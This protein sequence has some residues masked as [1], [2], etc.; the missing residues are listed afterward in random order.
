MPDASV[1]SA[2]FSHCRSKFSNSD[3]T[4]ISFILDGGTLKFSPNDSENFS[5]GFRL[6]LDR[7]VIVKIS[8]GLRQ[9]FEIF[10]IF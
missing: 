5:S 8:F 2:K 6:Y 7:F 4:V 1:L 9:K 3:F 10:K